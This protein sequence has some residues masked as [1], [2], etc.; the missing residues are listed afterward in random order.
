MVSYTLSKAFDQT[1]DPL[2]GGVSLPPDSNDIEGE[3]AR[4]DNDQRHRA[5]FSGTWR[6]NWWKLKFSPLVTY[7]SGTPFNVTLGVD[8]NTDGFSQ[9]RPAGVGRNSG[10]GTSMA[11]INAA[12]DEQ[13]LEPFE[14]DLSEPD[15]LQVDFRISRMFPMGHSY[16]EAYA[17]VFNVFDRANIGL[18]DGAVNSPTF[19][20]SLVVVGPPRIVELGARFG[21]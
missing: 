16:L 14:G 3:R 21:F 12:R 8:A 5:V 9:E 17:Q 4:A 1:S 10:A 19:G 2:K 7:A 20:H 6:S 11:A 18:I 13:G 15:F